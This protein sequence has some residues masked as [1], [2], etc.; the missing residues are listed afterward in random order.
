VLAWSARRRLFVR[1]LR[2]AVMGE[3]WRLLAPDARRLEELEEAAREYLAW[4]DIT[5][6]VKQLD[7]T[8]NQIDLA[9]TRLTSANDVTD[10]RISTIYIWVIYPY[11]PD[12]SKPMD[13]P[14]VKAESQSTELALRVSEKL[15]REGALAAVHSARNIHHYLAGPLKAMWERGYV[16]AGELWNLYTTYPYLP[17]LRDRSVLEAG[18]RDMLNS[19]TWEQDGFALATS[20]DNDSGEFDGLAIPH[21]DSFGLITDAALLVRPDIALHQRNAATPEPPDEGPVSGSEGTTFGDA[22]SGG[23]IA[24]GTEQVKVPAKPRAK[25]RFFGVFRVDP[26]KYGRDLTRLQQEILPHLADADSGD[27]TITVEI[28]A[29]RPDG[30]T[31]DKIRILTENSRVLK[32]EQSDFE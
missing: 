27:L 1:R 31:D 11:Q 29:T 7:L 20:R 16:S 3:G 14:V 5:G 24:P 6:R 28:E 4:K 8:Q 13:L 18:L 23:T 12:P 25:T 17:R 9:T 22:T 32:F 10:Q 26:Q 19:I 21:L 2:L 15:N 30:F